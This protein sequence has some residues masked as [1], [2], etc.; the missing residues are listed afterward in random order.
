MYWLRLFL[1]SRIPVGVMADCSHMWP[2]NATST[3]ERDRSRRVSGP[4]WVRAARAHAGPE[5]VHRDARRCDRCGPE[6]SE[7]SQAVRRDTRPEGA[8]DPGRIRPRAVCVPDRSRTTS[9]ARDPAL[10]DRALTAA[11]AARSRNWVFHPATRSLRLALACPTDAFTASYGW[12]SSG[13][14]RYSI[15]SIDGGS[16]GFAKEDSVR[17]KKSIR[18]KR[19]V[20]FNTFT[21]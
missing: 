1:S 10:P 8:G 18:W 16:Y 5:A 11:S 19:S 4:R 7:N 6:T 17:F 12:S 3:S 20:R 9:D 14:A 21:R 2:Y 15:C 13:W